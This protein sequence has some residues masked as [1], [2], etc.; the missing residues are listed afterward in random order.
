[1]SY[2]WHGIT[3][4][5]LLE[6]LDAVGDDRSY[7]WIDVF[8]VAQNRDTPHQVDFEW[9]RVLCADMRADLGAYVRIAASAEWAVPAMLSWGV[10]R[11]EC[12]HVCRH[13]YMILARTNMCVV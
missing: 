6:S 12:R 7:F 2:S 5:E 3:A 4:S 13:V 11:H 10:R 9:A 8:A 1:M